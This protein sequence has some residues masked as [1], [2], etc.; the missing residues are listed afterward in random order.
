MVT[1]AKERLHE[2]K[3]LREFISLD[4]NGTDNGS[5]VREKS[6]DIVGLLSDDNLLSSARRNKNPPMER[7]PQSVGPLT[8]TK[9]SSSSNAFSTSVGNDLPAFMDRSRLQS[10]KSFEDLQNVDEDEA[11]A[12]ALECS[13]AEFESTKNLLDSKYL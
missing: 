6:K 13:K 9:A 10:R 4:D 7:R 12:M 8:I 3:T 2:I 11:M 5:C 1:F